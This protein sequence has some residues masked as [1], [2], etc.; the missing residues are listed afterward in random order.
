[1]TRAC[2]LWGTLTARVYEVVNFTDDAE[3]VLRD[4]SGDIALFEE[5]FA[6]G[7][8]VLE[9]LDPEG[10]EFAAG[11]EPTVEIRCD[12]CGRWSVH[13]GPVLEG[14]GPWMCL[15][16]TGPC[17]EDEEHPGLGTE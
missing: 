8:H 11:G 9:S 1:M 17:E 4:D 7:W 5:G 15:G 16:G 2:V 12:F 6:P 3:W 10:P 14:S 13:A